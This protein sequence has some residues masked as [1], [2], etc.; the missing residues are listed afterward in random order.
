MNLLVWNALFGDVI[1]YLLSHNLLDVTGPE[2]ALI[3]SQL[4]FRP[5]SR[6]YLDNRAKQAFRR[7]LQV[8]RKLGV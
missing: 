4:F 2:R 8:I 3:R 7:H 5:L 1:Q 6:R